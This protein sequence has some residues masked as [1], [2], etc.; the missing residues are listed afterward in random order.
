[1]P[2]TWSLG[3]IW[4]GWPQSVL[5]T[6]SL[7]GF[8]S[9][10]PISHTS[11]FQFLAGPSSSTWSLKF[12]VPQGSVLGPFLVPTLHPQKFT[13]S[14][15]QLKSPCINAFYTL[16]PI[17][18]LTPRECFRTVSQSIRNWYFC[19][20][21]TT[22]DCHVTLKAP[23]NTVVTLFRLLSATVRTLIWPRP[24]LPMALIYIIIILSSLIWPLAPGPDCLLNFS[25]RM[26]NLHFQYN[27]R[28]RELLTFFP[29][30]PH[31]S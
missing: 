17:T 2:L 15:V 26:S 27:T 18:S 8:S 19:D 14:P 4:H 25:S 23:S 11:P 6:S 29:K 9:Y 5:E 1:M 10:P 28:N 31:L 22:H 21:S 12:G 7:L 13:Q 24:T 3:H 30:C 16:L 20:A